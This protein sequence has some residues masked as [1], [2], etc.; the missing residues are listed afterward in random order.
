[1][2]E[3]RQECKQQVKGKDGARSEPSQ[4]AGAGALKGEGSLVAK[5]SGEGS[6]KQ[7]LVV[8]ALKALGGSQGLFW[9]VVLGC[10]SHLSV[11]T[12]SSMAP[13]GQLQVVWDTLALLML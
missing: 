6:M 3:I 12:Y 2:G 1:M 7:G 5:T 9:G 11:P 4:S 8:P 13:L 10:R